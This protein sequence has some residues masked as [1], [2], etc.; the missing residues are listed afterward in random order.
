LIDLELETNLLS[1]TIPNL[2]PL[3]ALGLSFNLLMGSV[4][5]IKLLLNAR[6]FKFGGSVSME[7]DKEP[8]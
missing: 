5:D 7:S 1:G 6:Y 3:G 8:D 2:K 4:P